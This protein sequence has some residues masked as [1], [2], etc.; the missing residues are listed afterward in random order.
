MNSMG[1]VEVS[2]K[3]V[4]APDGARFGPLLEKPMFPTLWG[5]G[6]EERN[7]ETVGMLKSAL[8]V[9]LKKCNGVS[10]LWRIMPLSRSFLLQSFAAEMPKANVLDTG[11]FQKV[12]PRLMPQLLL[13]LCS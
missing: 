13:D 12:Q 7:C 1:K 11:L 4:G 5:T 8:F 2:K 3:A 6:K 10:T 9:W